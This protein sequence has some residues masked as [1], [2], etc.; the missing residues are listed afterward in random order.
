MSLFPSH[1]VIF[2]KPPSPVSVD[3]TPPLHT[4]ASNLLK[5]AHHFKK[6]LFY[7]TCTIQNI[8]T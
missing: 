7:T 8:Y 5:V 3:W 4:M 6:G 2:F 1:T